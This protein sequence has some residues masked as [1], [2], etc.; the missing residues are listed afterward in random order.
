MAKRNEV[1]TVRR[2]KSKAAKGR[3]G[4]KPIKR[5]AG[6]KSR[7]T[8][9]KVA[10]K[11]SQNHVSRS[12]RVAPPRRKPMP[13]VETAVIDVIDEP[14][15]GVVRVTEIEETRVTSAD[16]DGPVSSRDIPE[17]DSLGG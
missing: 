15:P 17:P 5:A 14:I 11:T 4:K 1:A 16:P 13:A 6:K 12:K 10:A 3:R 7:K 8:A 9:K 2:T